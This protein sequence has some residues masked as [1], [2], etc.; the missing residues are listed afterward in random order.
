MMFFA[1]AFLLY[2]K[3]HSSKR[4]VEAKQA[5]ESRVWHVFVVLQVFVL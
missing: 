3:K 5:F 1:T 4:R 2:T